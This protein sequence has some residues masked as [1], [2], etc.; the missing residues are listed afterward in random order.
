MAKS[1]GGKKMSGKMFGKSSGR[2]AGT[3]N[4]ASLPW[5]SLVT[6]IC[7]SPEH[8]E[9][10][11]RACAERPDLMFKAAEHAFGKPTENVKVTGE[12]RMIQWPDSED[13]SEE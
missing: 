7:E 11:S 6:S 8:Q 9:A 1:C 12:F 4:K 2:K 5:K 3:P 10:L 13:V